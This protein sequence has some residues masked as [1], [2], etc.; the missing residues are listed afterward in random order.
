MPEM[1]QI[2][3]LSVIVF[4]ISF[5][6]YFAANE[7]SGV[8]KKKPRDNSLIEIKKL[9]TKCRYLKDADKPSKLPEQPE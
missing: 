3:H 6:G 9:Q 5:F 4:V 8:I 1:K 2:I 7:L